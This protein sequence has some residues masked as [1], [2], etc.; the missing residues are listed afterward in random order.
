MQQSKRKGFTQRR[1]IRSARPS[2]MIDLARLETSLLYGLRKRRIISCQIGTGQAIACTMVSWLNRWQWFWHVRRGEWA[3]AAP[4]SRATAA[5]SR[6][7]FRNFSSSGPTGVK[8]STKSLD[9]VSLVSQSWVHCIR[10]LSHETDIERRPSIE[11]DLIIRYNLFGPWLLLLQMDC[12]WG[13]ARPDRLAH[14]RPGGHLVTANM[15]RFCDDLN[16]SSSDPSLA[17]AICR[18]DFQSL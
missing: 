5:S 8:R 9:T 11:S 18:G 2:P 10:V 13:I 15:S 4:I 7:A 14:S 1:S 6:C 16:R 17:S 3:P 12:N